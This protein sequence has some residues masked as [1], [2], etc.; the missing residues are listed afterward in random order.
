[1]Q[2]G[3]SLLG[4]SPLEL[5]PP[6]WSQVFRSWVA[7]SRD[8]GLRL[9]QELAFKVAALWTLASQVL[10]SWTLAPWLLASQTPASP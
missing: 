1:M 4:L 5:L 7:E 9:A 10:A 2:L 3:L 6:S 8:S